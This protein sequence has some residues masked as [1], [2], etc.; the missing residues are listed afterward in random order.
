LHSR[1]PTG[2]WAGAKQ[3]RRLLQDESVHLP[4]ERFVIFVSKMNTEETGRLLKQILRIFSFRTEKDAWTGMTEEIKRLFTQKRFDLLERNLEQAEAFLNGQV[5]H[6]EHPERIHQL[7]EYFEQ[8]TGN[9]KR[10]EELYRQALTEFREK[11][12]EDPLKAAP[13]LNN[14]AVL[15]IHQRRYGEAEPLIRDLMLVVEEKLGR[16]HVEYATCLENLAAVLRHT[17]RETEA[18]EAKEQARRIRLEHR[19]KQQT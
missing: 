3:L 18:L 9:F 11:K 16:D 15:L 1:R 14:L 6:P 4:L 10:G 17:D 2:H 19:R 5:D 8:Y 12:T 7:A 13:T